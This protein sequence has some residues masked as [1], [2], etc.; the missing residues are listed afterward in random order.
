[1]LDALTKKFGADHF[2]ANITVD[3]D[4]KPADWL[5]HVDALLPLMALPGAEVK[6][7]GA[8]IELSGA[9]ANAKLGWLDRLKSL[10]GA[11][12][13]IGSFNVDQAVAD[14]TQSFRS[15]IKGLLAPDSSCATADVVKVLNLQVINFTSAS[16][17]VPASA[18]DDLRQSAQV[19][20][21]CAH[22]GK[23]AK[24]EV[25]GY[26][27]NVGGASGESATVEE[28]CR[29]GSRISRQDGRAG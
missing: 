21:A 27:D 17:H 9:A 3:A 16:A 12:Y 23:A 28:A 22:N 10:F 2:T 18:V 11:S 20:M 19:L 14:A 4:T 15:A 5:S 6:V 29:I 1:M 24:L 26:S 7:N 13:Q 8:H 25:A